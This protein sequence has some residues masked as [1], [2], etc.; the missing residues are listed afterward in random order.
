MGMWEVFTTN[1]WISAHKG[2]PRPP[3]DEKKFAPR[4]RGGQTGK[5][6]SKKTKNTKKIL[7]LLAITSAKKV[8][9]SEK[10]GGKRGGE[11]RMNE[12]P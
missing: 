1:R 2:S 9:R 4:L 5:G 6:P 3:D 12:G 11:K 7:F 8:L 10:S